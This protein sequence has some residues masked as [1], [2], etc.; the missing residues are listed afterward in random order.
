MCKFGNEIT[1]ASFISADKLICMSPQMPP[2]QSTPFGVSFNGIDFLETSLSFT[3][4]A[5]SSIVAVNP[6]IVMTTGEMFQV[7]KNSSYRHL[8]I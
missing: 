8:I 5:H 2:V 4:T 7:R 3:V 1:E 6:K